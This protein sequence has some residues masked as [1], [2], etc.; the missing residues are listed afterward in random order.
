MNKI[1]Y[2]VY[3]VTD[4]EILKGRDLCEAVEESI[5]GGATVVQLREKNISYEEFVQLAKN[6]HRITQKY[7]VPLI[8]NDN[9]DVA[10]EIG[11]EGVHIGQ[12]DEELSK[13]REKVG[14]MIIG[15]SVE[16]VEEALSAQEGGADYLGIGSIFYTG[17]KKD[18]NIP[19]G[20]EGLRKIVES[21]DIPNV[22]I[23]G[24]HL[25]NVREVMATKTNGVA[26]ISEILGKENIR[27]ATEI[28]KRYVKGEI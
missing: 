1:D 26:V 9:V 25:D 4:R 7:N 21:V 27:E 13:V 3:L 16:N 11:A 22:A 6:L 23:G 8:I 5:L 14:D 24:I 15:V 17:S 19:I 18:I 28:L 2:S 12:S 10:L 20:I